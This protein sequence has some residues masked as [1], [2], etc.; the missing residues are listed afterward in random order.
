MPV[1]TEKGVPV[2]LFEQVGFRFCFVDEVTAAKF[3]GYEGSL[4]EGAR[5]IFENF[6]W[7]N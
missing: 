5:K 2:V 1:Y 7:R 3:R 4:G 6:G